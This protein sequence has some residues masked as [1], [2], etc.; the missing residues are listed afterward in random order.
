MQPDPVDDKNNCL[1][2]SEIAAFTLSELLHMRSFSFLIAAPLLLLSCCK[3]KEE[4]KETVEVNYY[5]SEEA[6]A[7]MPYKSGDSIV[8][9]SS[10][11]DTASLI[12]QA[13]YVSEV[14]DE[15]A[16]PTCPPPLRIHYH[17]YI[18]NLTGKNPLLNHLGIDISN[19]ED[20][21]HFGGRLMILSQARYLTQTSLYYLSNFAADDSIPYHGIYLTG[22]S[23]ES[24]MDS[25]LVSL[26]YGVLKFT[27]LSG[28]KWIKIQ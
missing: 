25:T 22:V 24:T 20:A 11:D 21:S 10:N 4:C 17:H 5:V 1:I 6:K 15:K 12:A 7:S 28:M 2:R 9:V 27:D 3:P 19:D 26:K 13:P 18:V 14:I 8:F 23:L 16:L